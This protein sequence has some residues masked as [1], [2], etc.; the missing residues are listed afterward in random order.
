MGEYDHERAQGTIA[1]RAI[2]RTSRF[3]IHL[4][5]RL[6]QVIAIQGLLLLLV[7]TGCTTPSSDSSTQ[8]TRIALSVQQTDI[9]EK[10]AKDSALSD[11]DRQATQSVRQSLGGQDNSVESG[12]QLT[13]TI[14]EEP[15][16]IPPTSTETPDLIDT[17]EPPQGADLETWMKSASILLFEDMIAHYDT[18]RYVLETLNSMGLS[19][20]D[21]GSA[22]GWLK[23]DLLGGAPG[24]GPWDLVIIAAESK[25]GVQGEFFEYVLDALDQGSS[26]IMEVWYLDQTSRGSAAALLG[27]CGID[28]QANWKKVPPQGMVMFPRDSDHPVL[29]MPNTLSFT[30]VTEY[31]WDPSGNN[32]YD[33]GDLVEIVPG[34][35]AEILV[36]TNPT[37][38]NT[39]GTVTVCMDDRLILQTF[40]SHQLHLDAMMLVWENYIT[41]ALKTRYESQR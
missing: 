32:E 33:I 20:K 1:G 39:H 9:A 13:E 2:I 28:F 17:P 6:T 41:H 11:A 4:R 29:H 12:P 38:R 30:K 34:G 5:T 25:S 36:G 10:L 16:Q 21:D 15:E 31:W 27:R 40:S 7:F 22:K 24:G 37:Y 35:D 23:T 3:K 8:G 19:Y 26:V 14:L 18:P